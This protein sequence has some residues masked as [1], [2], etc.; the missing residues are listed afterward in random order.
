MFLYLRKE[1]GS[2]RRITRDIVFSRCIGEETETLYQIYV[3]LHESA[4]FLMQYTSTILPYF[5]V[6][7]TFLSKTLFAEKQGCICTS[8]SAMLDGCCVHSSHCRRAGWHCP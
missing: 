1:T 5:F 2:M 7:L 4:T 8:C 6:V 3:L